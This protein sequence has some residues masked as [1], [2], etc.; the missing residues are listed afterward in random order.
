M[1]V[2]DPHFDFVSCLMHFDGPNNGLRIYDERYNAVTVAGNAK[3]TTEKSKFGGSSGSF[4]G[5]GSRIV[6][7]NTAVADCSATATVEGWLYFDSLTTTQMV[8]QT[9]TNT[10][11][12]NG[13]S[14]FVTESGGV[15]VYAREYYVINPSPG[16]IVPGVWTHFALVFIGMS[17]YLYIN[18]VFLSSGVFTMIR[19]LQPSDRFC[20]GG[21]IYNTPLGG[22][23]DDFRITKGIAR[24]TTNFTP[25]TAPFPNY[26][27]SGPR[28]DPDYDK[29]VLH[30]HFDGE[31]GSTT[32][33]DQKGHTLTPLSSGAT[34]ALQAVDSRFGGTCLNAASY[35]Q[36][37]VRSISTDYNLGTQDFTIEF[38]ARPYGTG[39]TTQV[40]TIY[41]ASRTG[42][43]LGLRTRNI[44]NQAGLTVNGVQSPLV[45][46][47]L[48]NTS[49]PSH[50]AIVRSGSEIKLYTA[51]VLRQTV[52]I[53]SS[54]IDTNGELWIGGEPGVSLY[55]C[56]IDEFRF[57][58]GLAR[59]TTNFTPPTEPF[60]DY[61]LQKL[62]GTVLDDE[63]NPLARTVRSFRSSDG[64]LIDTQ[65]SDAT[66]G[67][68][69]LR[70][71]DTTPHFVVVQDPEKNALIFDHIAPVI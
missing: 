61:A 53:G 68:F 70:A 64:L 29:V 33:V 55:E 63:G 43:A 40:L 38:F 36:A 54:S 71:T 37:G 49:N 31:P 12:M 39:H 35:A 10:G 51:G 11:G 46:A 26:G 30:C 50:V 42:I 5:S 47:A 22:Y 14:L 21:D 9:Y 58:K 52:S 69:E 60:P 44:D 15:A 41:N 7:G 65:E 24:Y 48:G 45:F 8:Y 27:S 34:P 13:H 62:T 28:T 23:L 3:L 57:T 1:S 25:P 4:I 67:A 6:M 32:F 17:V 2:G 18:G 56:A 66:T 16:A 19:G 59:Y 20:I